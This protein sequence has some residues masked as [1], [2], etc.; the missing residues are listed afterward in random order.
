MI[1]R[2]L[3]WTIALL[4][5]SYVASGLVYLEN[6]TYVMGE[7]VIIQIE[8][9]NL[10][11]LWL[12]LTRPD[13]TATKIR[14][15]SKQLAYLPPLPGEYSI[16][17]YGNNGIGEERAFSVVA[18]QFEIQEDEANSTKPVSLT[19]REYC[20]GDVVEIRI[21]PSDARV[22][23]RTPDGTYHSS[24]R[25]NSLLRFYPKSLGNYTLEAYTTN[26]NQL[27]LHFSV[28]DCSSQTDAARDKRIE[29]RKLRKSEGVIS[30]ILK[31][32]IGLIGI[33][34]RQECSNYFVAA[35]FLNTNITFFNVTNGARFESL[36]RQG[37]E[38]V[39]NH[40]V[41]IRGKRVVESF[42]IDPTRFNFSSAVITRR[43]RGRYLYKCVDYNFST[44]ECYGNF[45]KIMDLT[46]GEQYTILLTPEDPLYSEVND[47]YYIRC[48]GSA[49]TSP[50]ASSQATAVCS[51]FTLVRINVPSG[52]IDGFVQRM[53]YNV[54]VNLDTS[55]TPV[56]ADHEAELDNDQVED[57]LNEQIIGSSTSTS[58]F[59]E[60][61]SRVDLP[62]TG[63][64]AFTKDTCSNWAQGYCEWY[65]HI[66]SSF[67]FSGSRKTGSTE[68]YINWIN[69][70]WNYTI[71]TQPP[72]LVLVA[73]ADGVYLNSATV[74]FSFNVSDNLGISN[75]SLIV[76]G[77]LNKT[78]TSI[79]N[80]ATNY[81]TSTLTEGTHTWSINCTDTAGNINASPQRTL[82]LD[83][84]APYVAYNPGTPPNNS[85]LAQDWILVNI[86]ATDTNKDTVRLEWQGV[87]ES[88]DNV[89][90]DIYWENKTALTDGVYSFMVYVND[91]A[92]NLNYTEERVVTLDTLE[93]DVSLNYP[94]STWINNNSIVFR[95][96]PTDTNLGNCSL[97]GNWSGWH[98]NQTQEATSGVENSFSQINLSDGHYK[99]NVQCF[100]LANNEGW[101]ESNISFYLDTNAPIINL[102]SPENDSV[103]NTSNTVV[104]NFNVS[105]NFD[106]ITQCELFVDDIL[107]D[108]MS[109]PQQGTT[110]NFTLLLD[111]GNYLWYINCTDA[112]NNEGKSD[113]YS[114]QVNLSEDTVGPTITLNS[115]AH[116]GYL[117][118]TT[119]TFV[120]TPQDSTGIENCTLY[121]NGQENGTD[122]SV[123]NNQQNN[124]TRVLT[125]S[126]YT[127]NITCY[128]NSTNHNLGASETRNF[129]VDTTPPSPFQLVSP[130]N[131]SFSS[132]VTLTLNWTNTSELHFSNYTIEISEVSSFS[133]INYTY[134]TFP[135]TN[136]SKQVSLVENN[137]WYWRVT[138]Y[139][140][141]GNSYTTSTFKY[142][143][144]TL[145][146]T[147]SLIS[148]L[149]DTWSSSSDI[150]F[151]FT[152][153]ENFYLAE[154]YL[155]LNDNANE[156]LE[157]PINNQ[158][159]S[160]QVTGLSS[161]VYWWTVNCT[162]NASNTGTNSS[163]RKLTVDTL[164]PMVH[165]YEAAPESVDLGEQVNITVNVTDNFNMDSVVAE[166]HQPQD[167]SVVNYTMDLL[168]GSIYNLTY[169]NTTLRG[170]YTVYIYASDSLGNVNISG[171]Y[172]FYVV[173]GISTNK[174]YYDRGEVVN[175]T[176]AGFDPNDNITLDIRDPYNVSVSGYPQTLLADGT[177]GFEHIWTV[178]TELSW[179][180][181]NHTIRAY[182]TF[183]PSQ[184][185]EDWVMV[186]L[187]P[188]SAAKW[189]KNV[190]GGDVLAEV[191]ESDELRT[192]IVTT[193]FE[194]YV[195]MNWDNN[196]PV[197]RALHRITFYF[198]HYE[199]TPYNVFITWL[200][201]SVW[202]DVCTVT[203][204][205]SEG[206]DKC[207]LTSLIPTST[208]AS[209]ITLRV[210]DKDNL[211][212]S[213]GSWVNLNFAYILLEYSA[214]ETDKSIYEQGE[215]A[216]ISGSRW[217]ANANITI[218]V[219]KPN[220]TNDTWSCISTS[221]GTF[222]EPYDIAYDAP[223]G[224]FNVSAFV[225]DNPEGKE[226]TEFQVIRRPVGISTDRV[227]YERG[228]TVQITGYG[229]SP[230]NNVT[231]HIIDKYSNHAPGFPL[232]VTSS[233]DENGTIAYNWTIP[234]L[235][236]LTLGYYLI[237][238]NDTNYS[239]LA[240]R[241]N[242]YVVLKPDSAE[243][244][245]NSVSSNVLSELNDTDD[246]YASL[247]TYDTVE[248]YIQLN[249]SGNMP[250]NYMLTNAWLVLEH[251]EVQNFDLVVD[252]YKEGAWS[253]AC[254]LPYL[255]SESTNNCSLSAVVDHVSVAEPLL[256]RVTDNNSDSFAS[257]SVWTYIDFA[258]LELNFTPDNINPEVR[259]LSPVASQEFNYSTN[260]TISANISD[261]V[262]IDRVYA[263][264]S[265]ATGNQLVELVAKQVDSLGNGIY[266]GNFSNTTYLGR[267]NYTLIVND[268]S[269][270]L[271]NTET[272][273]FYVVGI[274]LVVNA[275]SLSFPN[276][277][278]EFSIQ[279]L[280]AT[281]YNLGNKNATD[282]VVQFYEGNY[283]S[284]TLIENDTI[285]V[286]AGGSALA[287]VNWTAK[288]GTTSIQVVVDPPIP[289]NGSIVETNESNN[290]Y[291]RNI[292]V[293]AY[294]LFYGNV[295]YRVILD[296]ISNL[297]IKSW[298]QG[299]VVF[300]GYIYA[301]DSD[302]NVNWSG[303]I[304]LSRNTTGGY[305]GE[306]FEELDTGL[307]TTQM[308]D[309]INKTY[310]SGGLPKATRSFVV[311]D[312]D[313][314]NV[315][316]VNSTNTS[317]FV[318]GILWDYSDGGTSF[319]ATQDIVF[320]ANLNQSTQGGYGVYDYEIKVPARL[321][322]CLLYT[323][324]SPRD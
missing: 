83:T 174:Q 127:W 169:T 237:T 41:S 104:F 51:N 21:G 138:A 14:V 120:Y 168:S 7:P 170:T 122:T 46:P 206:F 61:W 234:S 58:S 260:V 84:I 295:S 284:G 68:M 241:T 160:I 257:G 4:M 272:S 225:T 285:N 203:Y 196:T 181:G 1:K 201:N 246:T 264:V 39:P 95:Y 145:P 42:A 245:E 106:N 310:T 155:V 31:S 27:T 231:L 236:N 88:F 132:E 205:S 197:G 28:L 62:S 173:A 199:S 9:S 277:V 143:I 96:T 273:Y 149:N 91:S 11:G 70:T 249:F 187:K 150:K 131:N 200:N 224:Q 204:R 152:V 64:D 235:L 183:A 279:Q 177:G 89:A 265:W 79:T 293:K 53:Y 98:K 302:S 94:T 319:N 280:N 291:S 261:N 254:K 123:A 263:N 207:E 22:V 66:S 25:A 314:T 87:N 244:V 86:T 230:N 15:Y 269:N 222:D 108:T 44:Q 178:P 321:R 219:E 278:V 317:A 105:D 119:V 100:D 208:M 192:T 268:T 289:T 103:W 30:P 283:S 315:P 164:A 266:E 211:G 179:P 72:E 65:V 228:Q 29:V 258:Y 110:L 209:N 313:I 141:A 153:S 158:E 93:P 18:D 56:S 167:A 304:A 182:D 256:L 247:T 320:I 180:L 59:N 75:C 212:S 306:D 188:D 250:S 23:V 125:E 137:V 318:T 133:Y 144:D 221:D 38:R 128:D 124:F 69:Y 134:T 112:A 77:A 10:S 216:T 252:V 113:V 146:P 147:I 255:T 296:Q 240:N 82:Y 303:L 117:N 20:L 323:S 262:Y 99:W 282:V 227:Y 81:I 50:G 34:P 171:P 32:L 85:Y 48:Y 322:D 63:T 298:E 92:G 17:V 166:V 324:P 193:A 2:A 243:R 114:L 286:T 107:K 118:T 35:K 172:Y 156:T 214:L 6:S 90:G 251:H 185:G 297:T 52:A 248:D 60:M 101:A 233:A 54:T 239:N 162:D 76:D 140:L 198:Q 57:N 229:F 121:I 210:T 267:Y 292:T 308:N 78:N 33:P 139:D 13:N 73:P 109:N 294:H 191:N 220:G 217:P 253:Y 299:G 215:T 213:I 309:S 218:L 194:D 275:T 157:S 223:L 115:P 305:A 202:V 97:W 242:I 163:L 271:N 71:D 55:G 154:C 276:Q 45:E 16:G 300:S 301:T 3:Y 47:T 290:V 232:N 26:S 311:F 142:T 8:T 186:V 36:I 316:V 135:I 129:T 288:I 49:T 148:P 195:E 102:E 130:L 151:N 24:G 259:D 175:I 159:N 80:N 126:S 19:Q 307:N 238:A 40:K 281:V 165:S 190:V 111:N 74:S 5:V 270:N 43:A 176:G 189:D 287:T 312:K 274:D 12:N 37:I 161:G 226:R 67:T 136:T 116:D 184:S